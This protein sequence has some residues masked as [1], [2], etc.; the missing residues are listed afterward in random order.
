M[1]G[2]WPGR[3]PLHRPQALAAPPPSPDRGQ[4]SWLLLPRRD[5]R[6]GHGLVAPHDRGGRRCHMG[7]M[8]AI[9]RTELQLVDT[10]LRKTPIMTSC[11]MITAV[12]GSPGRQPPVVSRRFDATSGFAEPP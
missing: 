2:R 1:V 3:E 5:R 11:L 8:I 12:A 4:A 6:P 9:F 10:S 7:R